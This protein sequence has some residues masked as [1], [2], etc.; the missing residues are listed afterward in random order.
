MDGY[1][2]FYVHI[3]NANLDGNVDVLIVIQGEEFVVADVAPGSRSVVM[4]C[5]LVQEVW[6]KQMD[7]WYMG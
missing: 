1:Y 7:L 2:L 5:W 4:Y 6:V 3:S